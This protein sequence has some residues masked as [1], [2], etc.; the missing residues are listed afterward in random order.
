MYFFT[1]GQLQSALRD[2]CADGNAERAKAIRRAIRKA[3][4]TDWRGYE[5]SDEEADALDIPLFD[6]TLRG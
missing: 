5:C 3:E 1:L 2:A 6:I 4:A